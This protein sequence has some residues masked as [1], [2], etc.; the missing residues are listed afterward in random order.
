MAIAT[1]NH[2]P[3][4]ERLTDRVERAT[5]IAPTFRKKLVPSPF[6]LASPRWELDPDFDLSWHLRRAR[7]PAHGGFDA[8]LD[9]ARN[10]GMT[11]FDHERPLWEF[12]LMEGLPDGRAALVMKV[13]HSL[14]DG[15]GGVAPR[16]PRRRPHAQAGQARERPRRTAARRSWALRAAGRRRQPRSAPAG[17]RLHGLVRS[18]PGAVIDALRDPVHAVTGLAATTMSV[19]RFVRPVT[20][21]SSPVIRGRRLQWHYDTLD[22]PFAD[23]KA[24]GAAVGGTLNDAFVAAIAGGFRRYRELH[25][26]PVDQLR[27]TMPIS[28][29]G[30]DEGVGGNRVTLARFGVPVGLVSPRTGWPASGRSASNA[31]REP[32][33]AYSNLLAGVFN[34]LPVAV[35]GGMLKHVDLHASNV[36]GFSSEIFVG[37]ARWTRSTR[38]G[39]R[40]VGGQHHADVVCRHLS[41]RRQHRRRRGPRRRADPVPA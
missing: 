8:V 31:R 25:E 29:R 34:L 38:S 1:F 12:T 26:A 14:T 28:I 22:V 35:T 18:T 21:T 39:P 32:A 2:T 23:L 6:G 3:D 11:A 19:A 30:D 16:G 20:T 7:V 37:G 33:I 15:I 41:H 36:P 17:S 9:H 5:R 13:H 24:A 10:A 27:I 4:W 40:W